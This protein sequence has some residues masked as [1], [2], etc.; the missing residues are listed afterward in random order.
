VIPIKS[1]LF[2]SAPGSIV[3]G[4]P[5]TG[6]SQTIVNI[7]A[8]CLAR[9]ER[10]LVVCQKR[11]AIDVVSE[12][13]RAVGLDD[14]CLVVHDSESDRRQIFSDL[15]DQISALREYAPGGFARERGRLA[16]EIDRKETELEE[17]YKALHLPHS[18]IGLSYRQ[19]V[20]KATQLYNRNPLLRSDP[21]IEGLLSTRSSDD[22]DRAEEHLREL[23]HLW[24]SAAPNANP[25]THRTHDFALTRP[26]RDD[27]A[28]RI[29]SAKE[30]AD[31]VEQFGRS[32][33]FGVMFGGRASEFISTASE[34]C[35]WATEVTTSTRIELC[36]IW[37]Q[38]T[39]ADN[40]RDLQVT[41]KE[42]EGISALASKFIH[43]APNAA[44]SAAV[45]R[46]NESQLEQVIQAI[47]ALEKRHLHGWWR[48]LTPSYRA[49]VRMWRALGIED[50]L[51]GNL[52]GLAIVRQ[53]CSRCYD[54]RRAIAG[55]R[56]LNV[57][58][59]AES[60]DAI[61]I[62]TIEDNLAGCRD[63]FKLREAAKANTFIAEL[64]NAME[65]KNPSALAGWFKSIETGI[66]R[67]R[68]LENLG[69]SLDELKRW[70]APEYLA[71]I[72]AAAQQGKRVGPEIENLASHLDRVPHLCAFDAACSASEDLVTK[73]LACLAA[74]Q[75]QAGV[76]VWDRWKSVLRYSA[77]S[78]WINSCLKQTPILQ[79]L[80]PELYERNRRALAAAISRKRAIEV[81]S[82][83][84]RW[85]EAQSILHS[86]RPSPLV[87]L[88]KQLVTRGP[89]SKRLRQAVAAG[90]ESG[91]FT[92]RPCWMMNPNTACQIFQ[93]NSGMFDVI[94][95]DE[96]S[97]CPLEQAVPILYRGRRVV[98]AGDEK[99]LPPTSF[100]LSATPFD[101]EENS[102]EEVEV[103]IEDQLQR[104]LIR[105]VLA[106][107][108]LLTVCDSVLRNSYL[109]MHYRSEHPLLIQFSNKAFYG[110]RLQCP[111]NVTSDGTVDI[112]I[113]VRF[114]NGV[115]ERQTNE[116]EG[117]SVVKL[118]RELWLEKGFTGTLGVVTFN[119][120]QEDLIQNLLQMEALRDEPF[121][122]KYET[123]C[124]RKDG[125]QDV[126]F[127]VK[128]LESVQGDERDVMIFSTTFGLDSIGQ[129]K[130][131]FGP[132]NREGGE[133]RLNVA[134]TRAKK[135]IFI[136]T[137]LPVSQI[138]DVFAS[139]GSRKA[140]K[141]S[142]RDYLQAY[143]RY[144]EAV[145]KDDNQT[146]EV[147]ERQLEELAKMAGF[148]IV[149]AES[150]LDFDSEF[151]VAVFDALTKHGLTVD[152]QVG[153]SGFRIDL[154]VR[155]P[156]R[157]DTY[158]L[159]IEC[160]GRS[161]HSSFTAR[162]RDIWRQ[163]ILE[164]RGWTIH[165]IWSTNWWMDPDA[166]VA[167]ILSRIQSMDPS[168]EPNS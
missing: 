149:G 108:D 72:L 122:L 47:G 78:V 19:L 41:T 164:S 94:I 114:A 163:Q 11:A 8:D 160:D 90:A 12:R 144:A 3:H 7:V 44:I 134:V 121:R 74:S 165:R 89:N 61:V 39:S 111:P 123:E 115:Y 79:S 66:A 135:K 98:V 71:G 30:A 10:V 2:G 117:R 138:S 162:A 92:L 25:W 83:Q 58:L 49:A 85:L 69:R 143:M 166:E 139:T 128:N 75:T 150:N 107:T 14:L 68:L 77:Y 27:I 37:L 136:V 110:G 59:S 51:R 64:K 151:E 31:V 73:L 127:F 93:L 137:S 48:V 57:G 32:R 1:W 140:T 125:R 45:G 26:V 29:Q 60:A 34:W 22:L 21:Q 100:F 87:A 112:P 53:Q 43:I 55:M 156:K 18:N 102:P 153:D 40:R 5:G 155:N 99:Q 38:R 42:L 97:Q 113:E 80:T 15:K 82:I 81:Q 106:T 119:L 54:R 17:Y 33:G 65:T 28:T 109:D 16:E 152:Q 101:D 124:D 132:L 158:A 24:E 142:G 161:Y 36:S 56:L 20:G 46:T 13:L 146:R 84:D 104:D 105:D 133:K 103:P 157:D 120:K 62:K 129:F 168:T 52:E 4:P 76:S 167:K 6:K 50:G 147:V 154:A 159:G 116:T 88:G 86:V 148:S 95:F 126:S 96:A 145:S 23:S 118:L 63:A 131:F 67:A 141:V 9:G 70:L 91:I 130:R 35:R